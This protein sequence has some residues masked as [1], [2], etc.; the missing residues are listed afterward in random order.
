M[1]NMRSIEQVSFL[2]QIQTAVLETSIDRIIQ[3]VL[4]IDRGDGAAFVL[5]GWQTR[6]DRQP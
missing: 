3:V 4:A 6:C 5:F 2:V 1:P